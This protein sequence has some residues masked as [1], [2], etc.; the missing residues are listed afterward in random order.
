MS[1]RAKFVLQSV[2]RQKHWDKTKPDIETLKFSPV[3]SGSPE[4]EA[5]YAASPGGSIE[6]A[7]VNAAAAASASFE[8]GK[9]YYVDFSP[10]N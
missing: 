3:M 7:T 9:E 2:T 5:F 4:N 8:I 10:A 1:V 6:L